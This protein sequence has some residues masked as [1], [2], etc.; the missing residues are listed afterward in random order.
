[1]LSL[2]T[3]SQTD[4]FQVWTLGFLETSLTAA[5][6]ILASLSTNADQFV[7]GLNSQHADSYPSGEFIVEPA[8]QVSLRHAV[9][10]TWISHTFALTF[11]VLCYLRNAI[12]G[13]AFDTIVWV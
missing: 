11:I 6:Q 4:I 9:D 2:S 8:A 3:R 1:M 10:A 12:D 7:W 13:E 5:S